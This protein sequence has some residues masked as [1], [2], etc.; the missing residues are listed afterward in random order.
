MIWNKK[1]KNILLLSEMFI[2]FLVL[3]AV[4]TLLVY[5]YRNYQKPMGFDYG[6]VWV[7]NYNNSAPSTADSL[8]A[9]NERVRQAVMAEPFVMGMSFT[10]GNVP[11]TQVSRDM[12]GMEMYDVDDQYKYVLN[13]RLVEGRWFDKGDAFSRD[14]PI[15]ISTS[16]KEK[17]F[18][19]EEALG[20]L[21]SVGFIKDR[22]VIG[23][24][25]DIKAKGD[26]TRPQAAEFTRLDTARY[27]EVGNFLV[28]VAPGT[29][30]ASERQLY[31]LI[32]GVMRNANIEIKYLSDQRVIR[33]QA[34]LVPM[35][36]LLIV[37]CFLLS[38]V[39]LGLSGVL[40]YT[41]NQRRGEIGL[42]R[43]VGATGWSISAQ[44]MGEAM[45]LATLS[46]VIGCF[47]AIQFPLLH[48]FDLPA[49]VYV[50]AICLSILFIYVLVLVCS[51]YPG[52]QAAGIYP[53]V[54]LHED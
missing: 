16:L 44:L 28:R 47:F 48:V 27:R 37:G 23:V 11:F 3:F 17:M 46:L 20:K 4:F 49:G 54:A 10:H 14:I 51:F 41:I 32:A 42:R 8:L 6:D 2:S 25:E 36:L 1:G 53:A 26:Y 22:R 35:V 34:A 13:L 50:E 7:V 30:A 12:G 19:R 45:L 31:K 43:A 21:M 52:R 15:V 39:A 9:F 5:Y 33:N 29:G 40:W 24:V 18:G 38:N